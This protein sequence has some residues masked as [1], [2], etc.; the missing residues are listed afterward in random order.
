[1][2]DLTIGLVGVGILFFLVLFRVY[3]GVAL[4]A[5]STIGLAVLRGTDTAVS[6]LA[7]VSF[8]GTAV[9]AFT[10]LPMFFLMGEV[11]LR[12]KLTSDLFTSFNAWLGGLRGGLALGV[13]STSAAFATIAGSSVAV[14]QMMAKVSIPEMRK[15]GYADRFSGSVIAATGGLAVLIPPSAMLVIYALLTEE[16]V[17]QTLIAGLVPGLLTVVAYF[18]VVLLWARFKPSDAPRRTEALSLRQKLKTVPKALPII[19]IGAV[20][21]FGIYTGIVTPTEAAAFGALAVI[22]LAIAWRRLNLK[23][24][25]IAARAAVVDNAQIFLILIGALLFAKFI[26]VS[27]LGRA[28]A[29]FV[30]SLDVPVV[31]I[32]LAI[33]LVYLV[34]GTFIEG[35]SVLVIT[36]PLFA[37]IVAHLGF[38]L[39]WFGIIVVKMIEIS[40]LTPPL[41][42]NVLIVSSAVDGMRIGPLWTRVWFFIAVDLLLI[43]TMI[44]FPDIVMFLPNQ[45]AGG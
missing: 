43:G 41:G 1:M 30:S 40:L 28:L 38:D 6:M 32:I 22:V 31:V 18:A 35:I 12:S 42:L 9:F 3:L 24:I 2:T 21:I 15:E 10:I 23:G 44:F 4:I 14:T 25:W 26:A 5:A 27:G 7:N 19:L 16:S 45:M 29:T 33:I 20:I 36:V 37:P 8:T 11:A 17:G 39:I 13:L 34:L